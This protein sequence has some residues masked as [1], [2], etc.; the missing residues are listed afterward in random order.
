MIKQRWDPL[1]KNNEHSLNDTHTKSMASARFSFYLF[2]IVSFSLSLLSLNQNYNE[3]CLFVYI[4]QL[5]VKQVYFAFK[6]WAKKLRLSFS[7]HQTQRQLGDK[8]V[9]LT[10]PMVCISSALHFYI[11]ICHTLYKQRMHHPYNVCFG[12][13]YTRISISYSN[14]KSDQMHFTVRH[15]FNAFI[16]NA[17]WTKKNFKQQIIIHT[18]TNLFDWNAP[19]SWKLIHFMVYGK[20][21]PHTAN[22]RQPNIKR[23]KNEFNELMLNGF[24]KKFIDS[25]RNERDIYYSK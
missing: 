13:V 21:I 22:S 4:N 20:H 3:Y 11:H 1:W 12:N 25:I 9:W 23:T 8:C 7:Q 6:M 19:F 15:W 18:C 17:D 14:S 2:F 16:T 5:L 10:M 24:H